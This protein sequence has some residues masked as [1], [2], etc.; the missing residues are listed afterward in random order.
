[1]M[2]EERGKGVFINAIRGSEA[3]V[4]TNIRLGKPYHLH[5]FAAGKAILAALP[6]ER[7]TEIIDAHGLPGFT[8]GTITNRERLF[9]VLDRIEE[10]GVAFSQGETTPG[11]RAVGASIRGVD[12]DVLGGVGISGPKTRMRDE[13]YHETAVELVTNAANLIEID[14]AY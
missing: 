1:M 12:G 6:R 10:E 8:D 13:W 4:I 9:D 2:V 5:G 11:I 3:A 7:V 14:V